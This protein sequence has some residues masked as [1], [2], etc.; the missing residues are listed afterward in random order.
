[1][2]ESEG[3]LVQF[4]WDFDIT[5]VYIF[6]QEKK[7]LQKSLTSFSVFCTLTDVLTKT[8]GGMNN[9]MM[10]V[11]QSIECVSVTSSRQKNLT[12]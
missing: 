2:G 6:Y 3:S 9:P 11:A 4:T 1:M 5:E 7:W 10:S 8:G 12:L